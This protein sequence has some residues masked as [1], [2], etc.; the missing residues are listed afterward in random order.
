[1]IFFVVRIVAFVCFSFNL[2]GS[3]SDLSRISSENAR[4]RR[5]RRRRR[6]HRRRR[7]RRR[8][9]RLRNHNYNIHR[10]V[11][12]YCELQKSNAAMVVDLQI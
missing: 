10:R 1:M 2:P 11:T 5:H 7:R 4:R 6:R 8:R 3:I 9:A 12:E